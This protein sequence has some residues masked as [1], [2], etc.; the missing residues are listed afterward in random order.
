[1][2]QLASA[3]EL[4]FGDAVVV[5]VGTLMKAERLAATHLMS[6]PFIR[7]QV[8]PLDGTIVEYRY[9]AGRTLQSSEDLDRIKP[10]TDVLTDTAGHV[11]RAAS[12]HHELGISKKLGSRTLAVSAYQD[13]FANGMIAGSGQMDASGLHQADVVVDAATNSFRL[14]TDGYSARGIGVSF[15]QPITPSLAAWMEYDLGT[16][17]QSGAVGAP[18]T[19]TGISHSASPHTSHAASVAV[20]GKILRTGTALKAE[21]R[22][23]PSNTLSQ[24]N[25]YN[26]DPDDAYFGIML[27]QRIWFGRFLPDGIDAVI[28]ATNLLEQGYQ[29]VL[30][31]DGHTL[32]LAQVPRTIQA[33]LAFNF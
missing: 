6:D 12:S 29:P 9:A 16:A 1:M 17:L 5:D 7:V 32:F 31:P 8:R 30:S 27:K 14:R 18:G 25:A 15:V 24:V 19:L 22:W 10:Q 2:L 21:Y 4:R 28:E 13:H 26:T 33:G 11:L 20:R 3:Q 23:Q